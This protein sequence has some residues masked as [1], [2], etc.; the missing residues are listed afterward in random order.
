MS[1]LG[2]GAFC[3]D[4]HFCEIKALA[5][6]SDLGQ[7][8]VIFVKSYAP[9]PFSGLHIVAQEGSHILKWAGRFVI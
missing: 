8:E 1:V 5:R 4:E 7:V 9:Q 6:G 3:R 2:H